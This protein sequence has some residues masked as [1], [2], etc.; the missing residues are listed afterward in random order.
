MNKD[1]ERFQK[2]LALY[3]VLA[4][5][6][7]AVVTVLI[8]LGFTWTQFNFVPLGDSQINNSTA[9]DIQNFISSVRSAGNNLVQ[10]GII[11]LIAGITIF[12]GVITATKSKSKSTIDE[13]SKTDLLNKEKAVELEKPD[14][15]KDLDEDKNDQSSN[16]EE[17]RLQKSLENI[18]LQLQIEEIRLEI[19]K[20]K[21][22]IEVEKS[23]EKKL[24]GKASDTK[25]K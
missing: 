5:A 11:L 19:T 13:S 22:Q 8:T 6:F 9:K 4:T 21:N 1:D 24:K 10:Y 7:V 25:K 17:K 16:S 2:S 12:V 14:K 15:T 20:L 3:S 18:R 23:N